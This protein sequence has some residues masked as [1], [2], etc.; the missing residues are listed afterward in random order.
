MPLHYGIPVA[1]GFGIIGGLAGA[2]FV[3][4]NFR[5]NRFRKKILTKSWHKPLE[6]AFCVFLSASVFFLVPYWLMLANPDNCYTP[7]QDID[8][9][10]HYKAWC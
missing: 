1:V 7:E 2:L 10:I 4:V 8:P 3:A 5:I 9:H 6:S